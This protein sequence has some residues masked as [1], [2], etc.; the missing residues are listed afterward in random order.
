MIVAIMQPY[1]FPYLGY[2]QLAAS[3]NHFVF[4]DD[5]HFIRRGH[6]N[7]NR[8]LLD[9][10]PFRFVLPVSSASQNSRINQLCFNGDHKR[11]LQ[12][13]RHAYHRAPFFDVVYALVESVC[14]QSQQNVARVC[15]NSIVRVFDYL[16]KP[17]Q[18][19]WASSVESEQ[20]GQGRIL[21]LCRHWH[22]DTYHNASGGCH[23]YDCATFNDQGIELRFVRGSF[24]AY[25]QVGR[26]SFVPELS[27]IDVL[28]N[29]SIESVNQMLTLG[30]LEQAA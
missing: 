6:I 18:V 8:I 17:L 11:F 2:Y 10:Q 26:Q 21:E 25:Y 20:R 29:N 5:A 7:R 23:L 13:L 16:G 14:Q 9:G 15:A 27:M 22:A 3:V 12:Q 1:F 24:P 28:M 19:S 4:L 30:V